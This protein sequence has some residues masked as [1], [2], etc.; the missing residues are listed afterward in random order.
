MSDVDREHVSARQGFFPVV[1]GRDVRVQ[2]AGG[3]VFVARRNV[4][5]SQG[6]G[7]WLIAGGDQTITQGGGAVL[8]SRR[9]HVE[10]GLVGIVVAGR[11]TLGSGARAALTLSGP[12]A[13]VAAAGLLLGVLIG[14]ASGGRRTR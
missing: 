13:V 3:L 4:T 6:G 8:V 5:I 2:E 9:A 11:V 14:R 1:V 7:Q 12:I 10:N